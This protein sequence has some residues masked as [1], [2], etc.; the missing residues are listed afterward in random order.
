VSPRK[1]E[2]ASVDLQAAAAEAEIYQF[3]I[4][5]LLSHLLLNY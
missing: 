3:L 2:A 1:K 4:I 5:F